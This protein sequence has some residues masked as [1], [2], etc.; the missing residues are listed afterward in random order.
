MSI[1]VAPARIAERGERIDAPVAVARHPVARQSWCGPLPGAPA[2][3]QRRYGTSRSESQIASDGST[4]GELVIPRNVLE[5]RLDPES[6]HCHP[7]APGLDD[8]I[9]LGCDEGY[10][11]SLAAATLQR[12]GFARDRPRRRLP[13]IARH[14]AFRSQP[15]KPVLS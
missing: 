10:Q 2:S 8:H 6:A 7:D 15:M 11:S 12:L 9:I 5:W 1:E 13:G 4:P 14:R 3:E